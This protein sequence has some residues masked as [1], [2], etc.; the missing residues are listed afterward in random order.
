MMRSFENRP[1]AIVVD[2]PLYAHYLSHTGYEHPGRDEVIAH[3]ESDPRKVAD[4]LLA[5]LPAGK[6]V[7]Y[8]KHM[9]HHLL[10]HIDRQ[11]IFSL[12]HAF[13][14]RDPLE[15]LISYTKKFSTVTVADTGLVQQAELFR[16]VTER[17]GE[18]PPVIDARDMLEQPEQMLTQL[19]NALG[20]DFKK[21]M[22][23]WPDGPRQTDGIWA[24][25]WYAEVEKTTGFQPPRKPPKAVPEELREIHQECL[26]PYL[27]LHRYRICPG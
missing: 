9:A 18:R 20:I 1:D 3:H 8:Q 16:L 19:C 4:S 11:W 13:L 26:E 5:D 14:I 15:V 12:S 25:H 27:E 21:E 7:F 6:T 23:S 10:P 17:T 22:L 2:E 24:K